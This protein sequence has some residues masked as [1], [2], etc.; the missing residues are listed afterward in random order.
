MEIN[1]KAQ[2]VIKRIEVA[3]LHPRFNKKAVEEAFRRQYK[4]LGVDFPKEVIWKDDLVL[5]FEFVADAAWGAAWD[6]ARDAAWGAASINTGLK[7]VATKKYIAVENETLKALENG[8]SWYFPMKD[9]LVLVPIPKFSFDE[10]NRLHSENDA[11]V[12]WKGGR[13]FYFYHGTKVTEKIIKTPEKLTKKDWSEEENLEIRRVIQDR[14]PD[15]AKK[16]GAKNIQKDQ[17]G[18]LLELDLG[19]DPEKIARYVKV[20]DAST[21]RIY[22]LRVPPATETAQDAVAWTFGF[23]KETYKPKKET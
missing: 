22:Y 2:A 20:K 1:K 10:E 15:F 14:I 5:G 6:A 13:K 4:L 8:L 21:L 18:D 3:T 9:K 11:A 23:D 16:L 19:S 12:D 7:D 17:F